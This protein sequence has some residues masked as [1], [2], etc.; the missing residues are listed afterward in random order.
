MRRCAKLPIEPTGFEGFFTHIAL[1]LAG[2]ENQAVTL[3]DGATLR[4]TG[5][6]DLPQCPHRP[7]GGSCH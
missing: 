2:R 3:E 5:H 6:G 7:S 4:C 1:D